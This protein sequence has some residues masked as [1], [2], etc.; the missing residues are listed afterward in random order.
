MGYLKI[1]Y[2]GRVVYEGGDSKPVGQ[3]TIQSRDP[4]TGALVETTKTEYSI[5]NEMSDSEIEQMLEEQF[6]DYNERKEK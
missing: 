4:E 1:K 2:Q 3:Q 5:S 6:Q